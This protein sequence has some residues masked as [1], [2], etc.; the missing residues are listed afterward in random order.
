MRI[1]CFPL[2]RALRARGIRGLVTRHGEPEGESRRGRPGLFLLA[3]VC[4]VHPAG[5]LAAGRGTRL[6]AV[7]ACPRPAPTLSAA[8]SSHRAGRWCGRRSC[9]ENSF[10][11]Y[12]PFVLDLRRKKQS[13]QLPN[14]GKNT[15]LGRVQGDGLAHADVAAA[16]ENGF[17]GGLNVQTGGVRR[18]RFARSLQVK[19]RG[20]KLGVPLD[21]RNHALSPSLPELP[22]KLPR[23]GRR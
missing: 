15:R 10:R 13:V 21:R 11:I 17:V 20:W 4:L 12:A 23:R 19:R 7:H 9:P 1:S 16:R 2:V 18:T 3:W 22:V 5:A 6:R 8:S 14:Y